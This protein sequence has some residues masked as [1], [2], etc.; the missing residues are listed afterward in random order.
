M[1]STLAKPGRRAP[2]AP[3]QG[4]KC[5]D[6]CFTHPEP[7][8]SGILALL[9]DFGIRVEGLGCFVWFRVWRV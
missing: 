2:E 6:P 5:E 1:P 7:S 3:A 4:A 8:I 9:P